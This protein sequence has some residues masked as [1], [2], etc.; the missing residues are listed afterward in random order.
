MKNLLIMRK[1]MHLSTARF[2]RHAKV[3]VYMSKANPFEEE[4]EDL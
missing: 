2:Q 1:D 4:S 3:S